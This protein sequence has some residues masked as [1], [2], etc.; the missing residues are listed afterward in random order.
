MRQALP[1]DEA[2]RQ[3]APAIVLTDL[4]DRDDAYAERPGKCSS[5]ICYADTLNWHK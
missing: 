5:L 2:D 4:V 3:V 1:L